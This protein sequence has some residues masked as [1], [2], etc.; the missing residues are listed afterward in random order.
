[1]RY[2]NFIF[3]PMTKQRPSLSV[4]KLLKIKKILDD[5]EI[6]TKDRFVWNPETD[7]MEKIEEEE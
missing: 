5:K 1:M 6:P 4:E 2:G 3:G 7:E